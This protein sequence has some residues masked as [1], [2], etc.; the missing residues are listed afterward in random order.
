MLVAVFVWI[1][2]EPNVADVQ[3]PAVVPADASHGVISGEIGGGTADVSLAVPPESVDAATSPSIV[4]FQPVQSTP[5][6][7]SGSLAEAPAR[8]ANV[9]EQPADAQHRISLSGGPGGVPAADIQSRAVLGPGGETPGLQQPEPGNEMISLPATGP[10]PGTLQGDSA[11]LAPEHGS[12]DSAMAPEMGPGGVRSDVIPPEL[13]PA[14]GP[15]PAGE[16]AS[17]PPPE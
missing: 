1:Q 9:S 6:R 4:P 16:Q 11:A 13:L 7:V 12:I 17:E 3:L 15:G 8:Q 10:G 14:I 2:R 5:Q